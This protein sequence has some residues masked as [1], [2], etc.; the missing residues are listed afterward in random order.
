M[1]A[2]A[3]TICFKQTLINGGKKSKL[4][5]REHQDQKTQ[6]GDLSKSIA[7]APDDK[8]CQSRASYAFGE[9]LDGEY[10]L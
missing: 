10:V 3:A 4:D 7:N 6:L 8:S 2:T 5:H 9:G 1:I